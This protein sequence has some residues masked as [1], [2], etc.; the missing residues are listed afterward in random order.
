VTS[1]GRSGGKFFAG[2]G[3]EKGYLLS[4]SLASPACPS[5][6]N[7]VRMKTLLGWSEAVA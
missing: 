2:K 4:A 6:K 1:H 3:E 7:K 5:G